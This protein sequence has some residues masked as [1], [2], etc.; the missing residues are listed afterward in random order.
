MNT[1]S[2]PTDRGFFTYVHRA[3]DGEALYAG[4]TTNPLQRTANHIANRH[5]SHWFDQVRSIEWAS[6]A[7]RTE[8]FQHERGLIREL[9][10]R[11]NVVEHPDVHEARMLTHFA[12]GCRV[13]PVLLRSMHAIGHAIEEWEAA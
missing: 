10:P 3:A 9:A 4:A 8:M 12:K 2:I 6:H 1:L 5:R 13:D 11:H 7:S